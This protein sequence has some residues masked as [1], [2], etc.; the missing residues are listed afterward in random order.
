MKITTGNKIKITVLAAGLTVMLVFGY[1]I[2]RVTD[3]ETAFNADTSTTTSGEPAQTSS[4]DAVKNAGGALPGGSNGMQTSTE[5][6]KKAFEDQV[7][8]ELQKNYGKTIANKSTQASLINV[9]RYILSLFPGEEGEN[10]FTRVVRLAFPDHADAIFD[11]LAKLEQYHAWLD[12][13]AARLEQMSAVEKTAALWEMREALF[14]EDAV[15]IWSGELL[16]T[17]ARK[18][19][20][21]DTMAFLEQS[22][23]TTID[24]KLDMFHNALRQTYENT[25]EEFVLE[26]KEM[27]AKVFFSLE[28]V[29]DELQQMSP[30]QRQ[31]EINKVRRQMG[32]TEEQVEKMADY[33]A[34]REQRWEVGYKYMA[35]RDTLAAQFEGPELEEKLKAAREKY[36]ADEA[37]T[38]ELEE[39]DGFYRFLRP[40]V[41]GRN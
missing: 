13:N 11:T 19:A 38:I 34:V 5:L 32:F 25:A 7:V 16:A 31:W 39:K 33:D 12:E 36:F 2:L 1:L 23:D 29:Q 27:S 40:R 28:S 10:L 21:Q 8:R 24:E 4:S 9:K 6:E 18:K 37:G 20:M 30:E 35:E 17:D 26:Y 22:Y 14:G 3:Q 15:E 41:Y